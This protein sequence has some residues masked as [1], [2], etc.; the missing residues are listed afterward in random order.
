ML[1]AEEVEGVLVQGDAVEDGVG[2]LVLLQVPEDGWSQGDEMLA[3]V[4]SGVNEERN[5]RGND[6]LEVRS[7][8]RCIPRGCASQLWREGGSPCL[9]G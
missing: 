2:S 1:Q 5:H 6:D 8:V 9:E 4:Q 7:R 3:P